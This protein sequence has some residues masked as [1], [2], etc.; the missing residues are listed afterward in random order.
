M[1]P[2]PPSKR[3]FGSPLTD[4]VLPYFCH[5]RLEV[6]RQAV[7]HPADGLIHAASGFVA[8]RCRTGR[9]FPEEFPAPSDEWLD[10]TAALPWATFEPDPR[11]LG[12][13][14]WRLMDD[15]RG[16]LYRDPPLDLWLPDGKLNRDTLIHTCG[17]PLVPLALLQLIARLP[18]CEVR[19]TSGDQ[20][21]LL[22]RFNGGEGIVMPLF[23]PG[24]LP[25]SA[26]SL[27]MP[28]GMMAD[29]R[30]EQF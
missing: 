23:K 13:P 15:K 12:A 28:K 17:G 22:F 20:S 4:A 8:I 11:Y 27:F 16:S 5:P 19:M 24:I 1:T 26:F 30:G 6:F 14:D 21:P 3:P 25:P 7:R 18:R 29:L 9:W 2:P 10:R